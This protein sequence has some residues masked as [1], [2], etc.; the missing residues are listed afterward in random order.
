MMMAAWRLRAYSRSN[1]CRVSN[2]MVGTRKSNPH[3]KILIDVMDRNHI[4]WMV[5]FMYIRS[6]YPV[7]PIL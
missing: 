1:K 2:H 4:R 6:N 5:N 3:R 7:D